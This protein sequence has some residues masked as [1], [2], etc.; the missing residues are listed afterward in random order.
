MARTGRIPGEFDVKRREKPV[1]GRI[2]FAFL[3]KQFC[4][5]ANSR[6]RNSQS[7]IARKMKDLQAAGK[8]FGAD[9]NGHW[10]VM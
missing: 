5:S 9:K 8:R 6:R 1:Q 3:Q 10:E 2:V 4:R 7:S